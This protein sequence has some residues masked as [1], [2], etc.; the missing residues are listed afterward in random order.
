MQ[1]IGQ[2]NYREKIKQ[3]NEF[4]HTSKINSESY[5]YQI[6]G[7]DYSDHAFK[8]DWITIQDLERDSTF[9]VEPEW[10]NQRNIKFTSLV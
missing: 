7:I 2:L 5:H 10:F 8:N 4:T 9:D 1:Y 6:L 3:G